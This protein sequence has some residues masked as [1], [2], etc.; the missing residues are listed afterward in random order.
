MYNQ[1]ESI[2]YVCSI[3]FSNIPQTYQHLQVRWFSRFSGN[4][5][6]IA[7]Y[8]NSDTTDSNYSWEYFGGNGSSV[9]NGGPT[10]S[11]QAVY[12]PNN[13]SLASVAGML[14]MDIL[15]YT[16]TN[17]LKISRT[18]WGYDLNGS[19]G[20][21]IGSGMWKTAGSAIT[22]IKFDARAF[23]STS[24]FAANSTIQLYGIK[25]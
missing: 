10:F 25:A 5:A 12:V 7:Y 14:V 16:S 18:M 1:T 6:Y 11:G 19:G 13:S 9:Y 4:D 2:R 23:G 21:N 17:K 8:Y 3:T 22:S 15:D 24:D 20:A